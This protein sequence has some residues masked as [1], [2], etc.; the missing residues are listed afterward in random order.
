LVFEFKAG[1]H[2]NEI[3]AARGK[4]DIREAYIINEAIDIGIIAAGNAQTRPVIKKNPA[5]DS[6][7]S[8]GEQRHNEKHAHP[9][10]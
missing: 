4:T 6:G 2:D 1:H 7:D 10:A 3:A 9:R 8:G 5:G